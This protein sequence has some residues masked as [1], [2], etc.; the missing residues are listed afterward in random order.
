MGKNLPGM[1]AV[2]RTFRFG[3]RTSPRTLV[4]WSTVA[5]LLVAPMQC[6]LAYLLDRT[7]AWR[8]LLAGAGILG[9]LV[10]SSWLAAR[11]RRLWSM[12]AG[13]LLLATFILH[14]LFFGVTRFSGHAFD[15]GFFLSLQADS[16]DVAWHQY[17][18]LFVLFVLGV[19]ALLSALT[20]CTRRLWVPSGRTALWLALASACAVAAGYTSTPAWYLASG[21]RA[22]YAP[23]NLQIPASRLAAWKHSPLIHLDLVSK[24]RLEA[25]P[26][27]TPRN[28]ILLYI[29]SGGVALA[30]AD[31]YPGLMPNMKRLI[32]TYGLVPH[33]HASSYITIEGLVNTQCGTLLPFGHGHD[34]SAVFGNQVEAMPCLGDVLAKA[35]YR[36][37]YLAGTQ[38]RFADTGRFL[39]LHGYDKVVGFEDWTRMGFHPRPGTWGLSDVDLFEQSF[40]ELKRLKA[41]GH[42]FNLTMFTIGSHIPGF[43]YRECKPYGDGSQRFLDAVHCTDQLVQQWINRLQSEGWLDN[44]TLLVIT[45]DHQIFPNPVMKQLFGEASVADHRLPFIVIGRHAKPTLHDGA[46]YDLAPTVLDLLGVKTNARFALGRSL[47]RND[48]ALDYYPARYGDMLGENRYVPPGNPQCDTG[49]AAPTAVHVPGAQPLN[50]CER[51]ELHTILEEQAAA[52]SSKPAQMRCNSAV[53]LRALVPADSH[54]ELE[55]QVSGEDL[56]KR[57]NLHGQYVWP[58]RPGLYLLR[59]G[60]DG[61]VLE[62]AYAPPETAAR[63][64]AGQAPGAH[65]ALVVMWRPEGSAAALPGWLVRLGAAPGGGVWVY[66]SDTQLSAHAAPGQALIV[67]GQACRNLLH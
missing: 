50:A 15:S 53:P 12:A 16:L 14:M 40:V 4:F 28:L 49:G 48:R 55:L 65:G 32:A 34:E 54:E 13:L 52:Y 19:I 6:G 31:R 57:F 9:L 59:L 29:E 44:D 42:P 1:D 35:G 33:I 7:F 2:R 43:V 66:A 21:M 37:S 58:K 20:L 67:S 27:T 22:W 45:G 38:R 10:A 17:T 36:Q 61:S 39:K 64:P 41:R 5:V 24:P 18:Y 46:G 30:P 47:M 25:K 60:V 11:A 23:V 56:S 51:K 63:M 26:A 3:N 8:G 62:Q